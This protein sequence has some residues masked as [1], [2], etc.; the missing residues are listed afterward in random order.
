VTA[1]VVTRAKIVILRAEKWPSRTDLGPDTRHVPCTHIVRLY[2]IIVIKM[3]D[4]ELEA[5]IQAIPYPRHR[6]WLGAYLGDC[7]RDGTAACRLAGYEGLP[8]SLH[9]RSNRLKRKYA[10]VIAAYDAR[11]VTADIILPREVQSK[12][13]EIARDASLQPRDRI[14]A[15]ELIA[16]IHGMLTDT[17]KVEGQVQI[18]QA[19]LASLGPVVE[20]IPA[21]VLNPGTDES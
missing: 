13:A 1:I 15:L 14:K 3:N 17:V 16:R 12:L 19:I 9:T 10:Q 7:D 5:S 6:T 21:K 11:L 20:T 4:A 8:S 18:K 2:A